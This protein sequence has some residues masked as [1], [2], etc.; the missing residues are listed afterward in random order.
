MEE[1]EAFERSDEMKKM[2]TDAEWRQLMEAGVR[3]IEGDDE[4]DN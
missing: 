3:R 2:F 1:K 4:D